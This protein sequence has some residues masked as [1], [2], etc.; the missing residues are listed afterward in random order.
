MR[1]RDA[2]AED[3][4]D[5]LRLFPE[6]RVPDAPPDAAKFEREFLGR[7]FVA[8]DGG[9]T[10]GVLVY[11]LYEG[12]GYVHMIITDPSARRRGVGRALM[13]EAMARFRAAGCK[14]HALSVFPDNHGAIALYEQFGLRKE[15]VNEVLEVKWALV[16]GDARGAIARGIAPEDDAAVERACRL[17][18]GQIESAR[19]VGK[20]LVM[21]ERDAAVAGAAVFD[22]AFPGAYPFRVT[23]PE[24][25]FALLAAIRP[26][27][28][29]EHDYT[30]VV[31]EGDPALADHLLAA[32]GTLRLETLRMSGPV[33]P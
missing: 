14:E 24:D 4:G 23:K 7:M 8:E 22:P 3:H 15:W 20:T 2:S 29:A 32:G 19:Q 18:P 28:R 33:P 21:I 16:K 26:F 6:L 12:V 1:L 5:F 11:K 17:F 27:A 10:V 13:T 9:A 25:A 31:V 30:A